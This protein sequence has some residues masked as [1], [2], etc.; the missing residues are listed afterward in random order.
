MVE[1]GE[2]GTSKPGHGDHCPKSKNES[3]GEKLR[4]VRLAQ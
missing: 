2:G 3:W 4:F 1:G